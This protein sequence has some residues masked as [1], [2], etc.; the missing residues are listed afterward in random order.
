MTTLK[1]IEKALKEVLL[2]TPKIKTKYE[3]K[4]PSKVEKNQKWRLKERGV[5]RFADLGI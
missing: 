4:K 3:N 1:Q 5:M 2:T